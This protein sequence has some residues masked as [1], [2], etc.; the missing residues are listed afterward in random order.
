MILGLLGPA[1]R[2]EVG[3]LSAVGEGIGLCGAALGV[4]VL[5]RLD[6]W[7]GTAPGMAPSGLIQ[8]AL[9]EEEG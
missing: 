5:G 2:G 3:T 4:P 8:P 7:L 9:A 6:V 1:L